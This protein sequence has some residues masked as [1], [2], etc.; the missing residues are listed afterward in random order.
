MKDTERKIIDATVL[1]LNMNEKA[2]ID[3]IANHIG[4]N[5]R[6]IHRHFKDRENLLQCCLQQM[7]A[8]C[9]HAMNDAYKSSVDPIKQVEAMFYAAFA[10]GNEY[11]FVKKLYNRSSYGQAL[12]NESFDY[13]SVK[14][15]WFKLIAGLQNCG[16][17]KNSIPISWIY[18]LFGGMID[19][20]IQAQ[21]TGDVSVND[22]KSLAWKSFQGSIGIFQ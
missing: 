15:K 22:I 19:I 14:E 13:E 2:S 10:I 4:I 3:E 8:K 18:N 20:A 1:C 7:M 21:A 9:N 17:I 6:T 5:R 11:F 16:V 12:K